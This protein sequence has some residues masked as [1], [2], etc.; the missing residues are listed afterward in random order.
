MESGE[1]QLTEV[2]DKNY[3]TLLGLADYF[4]SSQPPLIRESIHCLQATLS[5]EG[6]PPKEKAKCR[7]NLAKML[8]HFTRNV[9]HARGHL[10]Q[11]H[12]LSSYIKDQDGDK[13]YFESTSLLASICEE[14]SQS[15]LSKTILRNAL[16]RSVQS[17]SKN[18]HYILIFQLA[19][20]HAHDKEFEVAIDL[21]SAVG[22]TTARQNQHP[23]V[24]LMYMLSK[25]LLLLASKDYTRFEPAL[26]EVDNMKKVFIV[27]TQSVLKR[28]IVKVFFG[29]LKVYYLT[30]SGKPKTCKED[31]KEL[32]R[33]I[34]TL[35]T[36]PDEPL[37]PGDAE[38]FHWMSK[39]NLC[40]LVYLVTIMHSIHSGFMEKAARHTEKALA[41]I[42]KVKAAGN[43]SQLTMIFNLSLLEHAVMCKIVQGQGSSAIQDIGK[44]CGICSKDP[45]LA[46][47][48]K[49]AVHAL[50]GLYAMS[51][52][53]MGDA[54]EQFK[55][56]LR[57]S[58]NKCDVF[59]LSALNL[60]I[61]YVRHGPAKAT[62]FQQLLESLESETITR[63]KNL[64]SSYF[65]MMGLKTFFDSNF[66]D[67][68][69]FLKESLRIGNTED[70]NRVT[71]C[72]LILLGH[73]VTTLRTPEEAQSMILPALQV[74]NKIPDVYLQLWAS[75][76]LKDIYRMIGD[77]NHEQESAQL[78][79]MYT[80]QLLQD[81]F[82]AGQRPEHALLKDFI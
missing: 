39:D 22:E 24:R 68:K 55:K 10:E 9:G 49:P 82:L 56:S 70:L 8:L 28:E 65:Y 15:T 26:T 5:I 58:N 19:E 18:W 50:L 31:L 42:E 3:K 62:N 17:P 32:Q 37:V 25:C 16:E 66:D 7:L 54:E 57:L 27:N 53:L 60:A 79:N 35:A 46:S 20:S 38:S 4:R 72:S 44:A 67:S 71:A 47:L 34:Q 81:H 41:L 74:A 52:N 1:G 76:L 2:D 29:F 43:E 77:A 6:L 11:S 36:I 33:S 80:T 73:V 61:I 64:R 14:Q 23:Y 30:V 69:R 12:Q 48:A 51:M 59:C 75:S 45:K 78:H 40:I 21:L 63:S 13:I